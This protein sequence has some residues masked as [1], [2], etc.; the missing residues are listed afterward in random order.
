MLTGCVALGKLL[1]LLK[2]QFPYLE[3]GHNKKT[4]SPQN[5]YEN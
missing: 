4:T 1:K 5:R 2:P 3:S